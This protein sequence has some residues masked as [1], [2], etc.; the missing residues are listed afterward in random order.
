MYSMLLDIIAV[1]ALICAAYLGVGLFIYC[2]QPRFL[3]EPIRKISC[4]PVKFGL[5]FAAV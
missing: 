3:Y 1:V 2:M 4:T 5:D